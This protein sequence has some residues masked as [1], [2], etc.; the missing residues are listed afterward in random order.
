[1]VI[2][3]TIFQGRN[4]VVAIGIDGRGRKLVLGLRR[5]ATENATVVG[6]RA[7]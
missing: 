3:G 7:N 5:G 4:L 6:A 2:D 1:M